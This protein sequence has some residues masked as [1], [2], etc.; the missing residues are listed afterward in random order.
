MA[1]LVVMLVFI[2]MVICLVAGAGSVLPPS[3]IRVINTDYTSIWSG[4]NS[5]L[6]YNYTVPGTAFV[7]GLFDHAGNFEKLHA[8]WN[9]TGDVNS[10][11]E[12]Y[13]LPQ[14]NGSWVVH[15]IQN[16]NNC[17]QYSEPKSA[18]F[19]P[20]PSCNLWSLAQQ[21]SDPSTQKW[22]LADVSANQDWVSVNTYD[23]EI[24]NVSGVKT[25]TKLVSQILET[26]YSFRGVLKLTGS[27]VQ[28]TAIRAQ[29]TI[30]HGEWTLPIICSQPKRIE[31]LSAGLDLVNGPFDFLMARRQPH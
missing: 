26:D 18:S 4:Y 21:R 23:L 6:K 27:L 7:R 9:F 3:G 19:D 31:L 8:K 28:S 15:V 30:P 5:Y 14:R 29:S 16:G 13:I 20:C 12:Y 25:V 22:Y 17:Y 1:A 10:R 2:A 11:V 24:G